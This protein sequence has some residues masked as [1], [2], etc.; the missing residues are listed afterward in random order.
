MST[1]VTYA[2]GVLHESL[3]HERL[4]SV[5]MRSL[6]LSMCPTVAPMARGGRGDINDN[7]SGQ[8]FTSTSPCTHVQGA[9]GAPMGAVGGA[10]D[11]RRSMRSTSGIRERAM[12]ACSRLKGTLSACH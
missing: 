5:R 4:K 7:V 9:Y 6:W 3:P 1:Q 8:G 10:A 12:A 11:G 2:L